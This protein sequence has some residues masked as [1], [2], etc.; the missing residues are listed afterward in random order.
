[1]NTD[2]IG[3]QGHTKTKGGDRPPKWSHAI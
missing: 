1:M 3:N 2:K